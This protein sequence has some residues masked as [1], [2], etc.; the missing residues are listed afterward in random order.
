MITEARKITHPSF[1]VSGARHKTC[2]E[3]LGRMFEWETPA[4]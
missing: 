2:T 4:F 3:V 1:V